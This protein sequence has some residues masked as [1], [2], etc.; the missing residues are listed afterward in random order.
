MFG[1]V[2]PE[3]LD[4]AEREDF[5]IWPENV[6][7]IQIFYAVQTQWRPGPTGYTGLDYAG[8]RAALDMMGRQVTPEL[9]E[10]IR[11]MELAALRAMRGAAN[12]S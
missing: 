6:E 1:G 10:Q 5:E 7:P 2:T 11:T 3:F 4:A 12:D 8:V 9:F